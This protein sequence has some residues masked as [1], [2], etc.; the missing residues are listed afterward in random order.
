MWTADT[1]KRLLITTGQILHITQCS[2]S[3]DATH[4][5]EHQVSLPHE[6]FTND[7]L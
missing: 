4:L 6:V 5:S 7:S 2:V 1:T 3:C